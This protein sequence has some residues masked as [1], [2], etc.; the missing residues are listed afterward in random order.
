MA[1]G[2]SLWCGRERRPALLRTMRAVTTAQLAILVT[3]GVGVG[4]PALA[5]FFAGRREKRQYEH[6]RDVRDRD[7]LR[8]RLDS[9]AEA[10]G[11]LRR[12]AD[13][14]L[15]LAPRHPQEGGLPDRTADAQAAVRDTELALAKLALW[16]VLIREQDEPH[17]CACTS[18]TRS[19]AR[20]RHRHR[21]VGTTSR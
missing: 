9:V 1:S 18:W 5:A 2:S 8:L 15:A 3:G 16:K 4:T 7:V 21:G 20:S 6:E 10:L 11:T 17:T 12:C 19:L 13:V 14:L